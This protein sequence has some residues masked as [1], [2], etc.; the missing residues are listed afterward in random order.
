MALLS[1]I[2][3]GLE[4]FWEGGDYY[5][6][7]TER[8][9][10]ELNAAKRHTAMQQLADTA[11]AVGERVISDPKGTLDMVINDAKVAVWGHHGPH[12]VRDTANFVKGIFGIT[13][14]GMLKVFNGFAGDSAPMHFERRDNAVSQAEGAVITSKFNT[15]ASIGEMSWMIYQGRFKYNQELMDKWT[16]YND[17]ETSHGFNCRTYVNE[18]DKQVVV[19][20]EG[21]Q[22]NSDLSTLWICKDGLTDAEIGLGII[23][24]QMREGYEE[25]KTI[26]ADISNKFVDNGYNISFAGHSLGGGLAQMLP[27]MYYIDTGVALPTL[28]EAGP[29]M[30]K[31]LKLY[32]QE[33]LLA[34]KSIHLPSGN[35]VSL[36]SGSMVDRAKEA[37]AIVDTFKAR[38][39]SFVTNM[40]TVQDPVGAVNYDADPEKDGHIGVSIIV[41]YLMTTRED[42]QDLE[43]DVVDGVNRKHFV[44]PE[45]TD[46]LG[47]G[48]I[49]ATR[50]DRHEPDQSAVLW[51]GTA[52]GFKDP[53]I[54]GLGSAVY[55][56]YGEPRKVWEGSSLSL[57]EVTMFGTSEND[58][59][60][61]GDKATQVYAGDGNDVIKGGNVGSILAGGH[62]DDYI[63][64]GSG[65][66]YLAGENGDDSLHGGAGNDIL[67]GGDGNDYLDGGEG[68]D[69]LF[70][71]HGDDTLVWSKG[72]DFLCGN[73]GNDTM[74]IRDGAQGN[75]QL[76]WERNYSNFG[77]DTVIFEGTMG[78]DSNVLMNF[79]D[80]IRFQHMRWS[81]NGDDL[82]MTDNLGD[83]AAS[84][85]FK[86]AF[87][88]FAKNS[89][90]ID[91][92]F[93]NGRL[94]VDDVLFNVQAGSG[95]VNASADEKYK[96]TIMLG[97]KGDDTL[98]SGKGDDLMVGGKGK[99]TYVFGNTFGH[100]TIVGGASDDVIQF[101]NA[102][103]EKEYTISQDFDDLVI[104]YQQT[105]SAATNT[106]TLSDWFT[107][108][109]HIDTVQFGDGSYSL[110]DKGFSKQSASC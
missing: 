95:D 85:T 3:N 41:P 61:T 47:F 13:K 44:T 29:G 32:A 105:G 74:V 75:A 81:E 94:Y 2:V 78:K 20:L 102:F 15:G 45:L 87:D 58:Y 97:S 5:E 12:P 72:N 64:G 33:Q 9:H 79:A 66:D 11:V 90:N 7:A 59:I 99:D 92:Q 67:F 34:G 1:R 69:L 62:G 43:Y 40:I 53:S 91:M 38:D 10:A 14:D 109:D 82:V 39:F 25:F 4:E 48:N 37:K 108:A 86:D 16:Q 96:G 88:A 55:R 103:N 107:S 106:V 101:T 57:P 23:P 52:V 71:G 21:T 89:G 83:K 50:F 76:K 84:V 49:E 63:V 30:L 27:G 51:S 93:T 18:A 35:V 56:A 54:I 6:S 98:H 46:K 17:I 73:E 22:P 24:P 80:E 31:H 26:V 8:S 100:D 65:D 77:N 60:E 28:A 42:M 70:G 19:T 110:S 104:S 36:H 68:S